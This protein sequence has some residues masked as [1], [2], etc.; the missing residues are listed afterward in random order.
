LEKDKTPAF[1]EKVVRAERT[2][3]QFCGK[4]SRPYVALLLRDRRVLGEL[5]PMKN[6]KPDGSP[7]VG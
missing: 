3:S 6:D 7:L 2:R 5:Q 1:G 4:W